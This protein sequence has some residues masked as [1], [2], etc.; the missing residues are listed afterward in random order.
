MTP[1]GHLGISLNTCAAV[2]IAIVLGMLAMLPCKTVHII[3]HIVFI[4]FKH[5]LESHKWC[6]FNE[7]LYTRCLTP[8]PPDV[9][10]VYV[11]TNTPPV[12]VL[13]SKENYKESF[14]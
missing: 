10:K 9:C 14:L 2:N 5:T 3:E 13:L 6:V 11:L 8:I 1:L 7:E 12:F 4:Q